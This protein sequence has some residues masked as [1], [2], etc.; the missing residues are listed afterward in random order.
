MT[1]KATTRKTVAARASQVVKSRVSQGTSD[2]PPGAVAVKGKDGTPAIGLTEGPKNYFADIGGSKVS[3]F[4]N[5]MLRRTLSTV[6]CFKGEKDDQKR[7]MAAAYAAMAAFK[8]TNEIEGML[9][10][11][12]VAMHFGAMECFRRSIIGEQPPDIASKLRKDG[13]NLA[14]GMV[15][16]LDAL[17][18]KRGKGPQV[19]RV[20]RVV[21]NE[22]G[23]AIVGNVQPAAT[24]PAKGEG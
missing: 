12:A 5:A 4:N 11:Q 13:A 8:P 1:K 17:D 9:A 14:R 15:D 3:S 22:G 10:A 23:Q 19:V 6:W 7:M 2:M 21:V 24:G 20:E 18:R 16:M